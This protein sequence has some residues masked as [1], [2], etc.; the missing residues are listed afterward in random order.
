MT[1]VQS[2]IQIVDTPKT[3]KTR[4]GIRFAADAF[5]LNRTLLIK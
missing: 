3:L 1:N 5:Q 2:K 4:A